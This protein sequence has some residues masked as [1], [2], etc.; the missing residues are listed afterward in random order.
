MSNNNN[1][2]R[3]EDEEKE[4]GK[5]EKEFEPCFK[6]SGS[7]ANGDGGIEGWDE[8]RATDL[9]RRIHDLEAHYADAVKLMGKMQGEINQ[10]KR[11]KDEE[12]E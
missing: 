6:A 7:Y 9:E 4:R 3:S 11:D 2:K 5:Q 8:E 12:R 1:E 10:L